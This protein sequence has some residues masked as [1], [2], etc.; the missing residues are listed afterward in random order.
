MHVSLAFFRETTHEARRRQGAAIKRHTQSF[1]GLLVQLF[2]KIKEHGTTRSSPRVST[3]MRRGCA[4]RRRVARPGE[5]DAAEGVAAA[6]CCGITSSTPRA[7]RGGNPRGYTNWRRSCCARSTPLTTV[8]A[9]VGAR[10]GHGD[11]RHGIHRE[12]P[13]FGQGGSWA[14]LARMHRKTEGRRSCCRHA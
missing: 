6:A 10:A 14:F 1:H 13:Q 5:H 7:R 3:M 9:R 8:K 11:L 2:Y 12:E 4:D